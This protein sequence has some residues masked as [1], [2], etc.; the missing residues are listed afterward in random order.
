MSNKQ[1]RPDPRFRP[2]KRVDAQAVDI[3][4]IA[5]AE[6]IEQVDGRGRKWLTV[7]SVWMFF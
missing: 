5:G 7:F 3:I 6:A 4:N 2:S 1:G